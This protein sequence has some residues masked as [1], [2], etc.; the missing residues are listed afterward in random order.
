MN[1]SG[2]KGTH[3]NEIMFLPESLDLKT[4][5]PARAGEVGELVLSNLCCES[6]P[7]LRYKT[8]RPGPIQL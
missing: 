4:G 1:V 6:A 3:L 7:L 2:N 5:N 8:G